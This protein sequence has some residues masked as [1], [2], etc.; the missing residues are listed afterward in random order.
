MIIAYCEKFNLPYFPLGSTRL[1]N[2]P[3]AGKEPDI[4]YAFHTDK[5]TP[6][7]AIEVVFSSGGIDDLK[8]YQA[9]G[10]KEV[11]FWQDNKITFYQLI[12]QAYQKILVSVNL[13]NL[14]SNLLA[15]FANRSFS[16]SPLS[17]KK[18]FIKHL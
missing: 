11:W 8:K 4:A 5:D 18:D 12:N 7:L 10:V 6:D 1:K 9:I 2:K 16:E 17:I 15:E 14:S 3:N 13:P